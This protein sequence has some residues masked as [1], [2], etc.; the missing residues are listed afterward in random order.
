[1]ITRATQLIGPVPGCNLDPFLLAQSQSG[2]TYGYCVVAYLAAPRTFDF[3]FLRGDEVLHT[4]RMTDEYRYITP[5]DM[6][7]ERFRQQRGEP[8]TLVHFFSASAES[9]NRFIATFHF[10]P[11]LKL[12][13]GICHE[14]QYLSL[15]SKATTGR[16]L[17]ET[18][19]S[20]QILPSIDLFELRTTEDLSSMKP[21]PREGRLLVYDLEVNSRLLR[22]KARVR[23]SL[24]TAGDRTGNAATPAV[25]QEPAKTAEPSRSPEKPPGLF[26]A[27]SPAPVH[28]A[29]AEKGET[30]PPKE[31]PAKEEVEFLR[32]I[33]AMLRSFRKMVFDVMGEKSEELFARSEREV[34]LLMPRFQINSLSREA[35]G[36]AFDFL[37]IVA[38]RVPVF[39]RTRVRSIAVTLVS[40]VY[41]RH[42]EAL[43]KFGVIGK[44][45]EVYRRMR[46]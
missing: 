3:V 42:H 15:L 38:K 41:S 24:M 39:K 14:R 2:E 19:K 4:A 13:L 32:L 35:A 9:L 16:C 1:M 23:I 27:A 46:G 11:C 25:D 30:P 45:E 10:E 21:L 43:Q 20:G 40:E 31:I 12:K 44:A 33:D 6:V 7:R 29:A 8:S 37:E 5:P 34:Q 28:V 17:I 36:S 22:E 18:I 26:D